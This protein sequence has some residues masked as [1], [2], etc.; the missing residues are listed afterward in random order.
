M[1]VF[2]TDSHEPDD[3]KSTPEAKKIVLGA[4]LS[5]AAFKKMLQNSR[6]LVEKIK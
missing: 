1:L 3:L 4:G 2:N 6:A 5:E